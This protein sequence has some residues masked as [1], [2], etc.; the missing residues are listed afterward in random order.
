MTEEAAADGELRQP[1][2]E[3]VH[4]LRSRL[5]EL[6]QEEGMTAS[7]AFDVLKREAAF[8]SWQGPALLTKVTRTA[9]KT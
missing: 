2:P 3:E 9:V 6:R 4:A 7:S 8:T 1:S 5:L